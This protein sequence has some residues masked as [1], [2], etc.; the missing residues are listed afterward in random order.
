MLYGKI[1]WPIVYVFL[2]RL[3]AVKYHS[4]LL[5]LR[6]MSWLCVQVCTGWVRDGSSCCRCAMFYWCSNPWWSGRNSATHWATL[7][8]SAAVPRRHACLAAPGCCVREWTYSSTAQVLLKDWWVGKMA[9][10]FC[11]CKLC[12]FLM[13]SPCLILYTYVYLIHFVILYSHCLTSIFMKA[14]FLKN[15]SFVMLRYFFLVLCT[16]LNGD[17]MVLINE[18]VVSWDH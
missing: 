16:C 1:K 15:C 9:H 10:L 12:G 6:S 3:P 11:M 8:W 2:E 17:I 18:V 14:L 4:S 5:T 13:R 7:S